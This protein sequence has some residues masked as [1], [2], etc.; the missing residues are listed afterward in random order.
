MVEGGEQGSRASVDAS[1][2]MRSG[3]CGTN[4]GGER[5]RR[6]SRRRTAEQELSALCGKRS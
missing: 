6:W 1:R 4:K 5:W 2:A 3:Q